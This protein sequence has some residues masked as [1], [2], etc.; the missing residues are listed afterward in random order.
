MDKMSEK[1]YSIPEAIYFLQQEYGEENMPSSEETLRR[2]IRAKQIRAVENGDPGR[3]GYTITEGELRIYADRRMERIQGR[4]KSFA[5]M[6]STLK[7]VKQDSS[8]ATFTEL[9]SQYLDGKI[10]SNRYFLLLYGEKAKWEAIA[11]QKQEELC[12]LDVQRQ[13]LENELSAC[14]S[15]IEAFMD[16]IEKFSLKKDGI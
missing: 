6:T 12:R 1:V 7:D 15:S 5:P 8:P 11:S 3:K 9:Y 14:K 4:R 13:I 16:G 10:E 2:A